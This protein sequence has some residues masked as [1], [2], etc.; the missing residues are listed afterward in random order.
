MIEMKSEER[1]AEQY[2]RS[3]GIGDIVYQPDGNVM[4]DFLVDQHVAI[5]VR[6]LNQHSVFQGHTKGLEEDSIPLVQKIENLL[7]LLGKPI[8]ARSW[9]VGLGFRRPIPPWEY[10]K[11]RIIRSLLNSTISTN[12]QSGTIKIS[13]N[14]EIDLHLA[15]DTHPTRFVFGGWSDGDEGGFVV[16]EVLRNLEIAVAEKTRKQK[17][18]REKYKIWWLIFV[19]YIGRGLNADDRHTLKQ[20]FKIPE[21]WQK[22][23]LINPLD[24]LD[25][26]EL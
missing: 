18:V 15:S 26:F 5:E 9:F 10:L 24:C 25:G 22:I 12:A 2:L 21:E 16:S 13:D 17:S 1:L 20:H 23:V 11:P 19:D 3:I 8:D 7:P 6:R 4:P 14:F